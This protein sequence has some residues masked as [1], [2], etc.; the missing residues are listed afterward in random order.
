MC[1]TCK[2][3]DQKKKNLASYP[4]LTTAFCE[5]YN[6]IIILIEFVFCVGRYA[7][8]DVHVCIGVLRRGHAIPSTMVWFPMMG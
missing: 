4:K 5:I 7:L 2:L 6:N 1:T 8:T 3:S